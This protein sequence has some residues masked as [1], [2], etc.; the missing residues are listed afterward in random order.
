M[1]KAKIRAKT[2]TPRWEGLI[3][4]CQVIYFEL[5]LMIPVSKNRMFNRMKIVPEKIIAGNMYFSS[6]NKNQWL[7]IAIKKTA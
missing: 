6:A 7:L 1:I 2:A 3:C 4:F 5:K